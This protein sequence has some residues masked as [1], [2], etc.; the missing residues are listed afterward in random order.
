ML[1]GEG[2]NDTLTAV[3]SF[4]SGD[5]LEGGPGNDLLVGSFASDT[6]EGGPGNDVLR[7]GA[8]PDLLIGGPGRDVI[9]GQGGRDLVYARD[10]VR[11]VV[12]CG[13][14]T[15]RTT[16]PEADVAYV[17]RFDVVSRDCE[18]VF[19]PGPA[20]PAESLPRLHF[21]ARRE[22]TLRCRPAGGTLPHAG[23]ACARLVRVQNPF[24]PTAPLERCVPVYAG[25][26]TAGVLGTYGDRFV[27]VGF[28]RFSSC[29]VRRWNRVAFLFPI[30]V[31]AA[32]Q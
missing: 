26:Q 11:D 6:L 31:R 23:A 28:E 18:Y 14:N 9:Q 13:T 21:V 5:T 22:Y 29:G 1:L 8:G 30:R 12:S 24:A 20:P 4:F 2:G 16:G 17:D 32:P 27:H 3:A 10:G 15:G 19:R 25:V 7:G